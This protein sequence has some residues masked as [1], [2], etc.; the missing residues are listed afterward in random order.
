M[1]KKSQPISNNRKFTRVFEY[2]HAIAVWTYDYSITKN[3]PVS[4]EVNYKNEQ[5]K[6]KRKT[7]K[8]VI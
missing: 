3:G 5:S 8:Q 7:K 2:D 1:A 4:V 6:T